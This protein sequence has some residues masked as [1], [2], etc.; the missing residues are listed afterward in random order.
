MLRVSILLRRD[1]SV[2]INMT[3][4]TY[5]AHKHKRSPEIK[6]QHNNRQNIKMFLVPLSIASL[7]SIS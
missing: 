3:I 5:I 6:K 4:V 1:Y 2:L 7:S